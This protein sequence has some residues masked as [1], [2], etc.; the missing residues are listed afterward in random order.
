MSDTHNSISMADI[1]TIWYEVLREIIE[2]GKSVQF[3]ALITDTSGGKATQNVTRIGPFN[4]FTTSDNTAYLMYSAENG[5]GLTELISQPPGSF[6]SALEDF[7]INNTGTAQAIGIDPTR[8]QLLTA[9]TQKPDLIERFQQGGVVGYVI[10]FLGLITIVLS[11]FRIISLTGSKQ[12]ITQQLKNLQQISLD[13]AL[14]R[15]INITKDAAELDLESMELKLSEAIHRETPAFTRHHNVLKIIA[16]VAPLLGL[17][18]TVV[19]MIITFQSI[20]LYGTGDPKLMAG[21]ISSALITTVLGL[22]V[23][24][25]TLFAHNYLSEQ[26][27]SL[28]QILEQQAIG[29][30]A[31]QVKS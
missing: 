24:I 14:G 7:D 25:P 31:L 23:A 13:N 18:G 20:T 10:A 9:L 11:T 28:T 22:V 12:R 6:L 1:R 19:G 30:L 17:L 2:S 15:I 16:V 4:A 3:P 21:G 26:A 8:G 5:G 27:K 29:Q